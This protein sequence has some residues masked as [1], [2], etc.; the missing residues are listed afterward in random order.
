MKS[1]IKLAMAGGYDREVSADVF[2]NWAVHRENG[3]EKG[4]WK[5]THVPSGIAA[6]S[7]HLRGISEADAIRVA[8]HLATAVADLPFSADELRESAQHM[9]DTGERDDRLRSLLLM[10]RLEIREALGLHDEKAAAP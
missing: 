4:A 8:V 9:H 3:F 6:S 2:G 7:E 10:M 1:T 5:I